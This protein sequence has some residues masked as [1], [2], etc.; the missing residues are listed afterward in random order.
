MSFVIEGRARRHT[1]HAKRRIISS[2]KRQIMTS[3]KSYMVKAEPCIWVRHAIA[4]GHQKKTFAK[5]T[6]G[7]GVS[8]GNAR[9]L[10]RILSHHVAS[11]TKGKA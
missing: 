4:G 6:C 2:T 3:S 5:A 10:V 1:K 9:H 11:T 7:C 8:K